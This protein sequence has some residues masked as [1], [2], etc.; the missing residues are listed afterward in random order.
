MKARVT[1]AVLA[2][3]VLTPMVA[4][5]FSPLLAW[6][7]PVYIIAGFAGIAAFA[8]M[9]LQPFAALRVLPGWSALA[10]RRL[11]R[12]SGMAI[13]LLVALHVLGLWLTSPPDVIDALLLRSPT[14]FS[15]WGV[16]AMWLI[17]ATGLLAVL[18][19][20]GAIRWKLWQRLHPP[21]VLIAAVGTIAH[22]LLIEG[23][24]EAVTKY[25]LCGVLVVVCFLVF[26]RLFAKA[27]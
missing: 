8:L 4:A 1:W 2:L 3:V 5:A 6:R 12:I 25:L 22:V 19:F 16:I 7:S 13:V 26:T 24:M 17:F 14:P 18:R 21:I 15:I 10:H 23:T 9:A 27:E 20:R 11:H